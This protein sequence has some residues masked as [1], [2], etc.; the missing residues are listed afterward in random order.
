MNYL[1]HAYLSFNHPEIL[2]GNMISDFVKGRKKFDYPNLIQK[3]IALH[4]AID[5]FTDRHEATKKAKTLFK[6]SYGLYAGAFIDIVY[7][8]FL[9]NDVKEFPQ[10]RLAEFS[11]ETYQKLRKQEAFFPGRFHQVFYYMQLHDWLYNYQFEEAIRKSFRGLVQ[12][13]SYMH[14]SS[15]ADSVFGNHV[16]ELQRYYDD[17]FPSLKEFSLQTFN[18]LLNEH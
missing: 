13:A 8:Y 2:S 15:A 3:G 4:R 1:A 16:D 17:F 14:D 9:A 18:R 10:N 5:E 11:G 12:R 6:P 7:D